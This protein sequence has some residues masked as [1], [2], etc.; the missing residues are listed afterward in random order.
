MSRYE[1]FLPM[2]NSLQLIANASSADAPASART[3]PAGDARLL[4]AYSAAVVSA[5]ERVGPSAEFAGAKARDIVIGLADAVVADID[6]LQRL[7]TR[8]R[9]DRATNITALRD[10]VQ[11]Q[12]AIIPAEDSILRGR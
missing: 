8:E 1:D 4:D 7:R 3:I 2:T 12:L 6:D 11:V 5:V 10:G 9:I